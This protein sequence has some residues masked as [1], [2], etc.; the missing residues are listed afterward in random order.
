MI[1]YDFDFSGENNEILH[2]FKINNG[3]S[4]PILEKNVGY[5]IEGSFESL[6]RAQVEIDYAIAKDKQKRIKDAKYSK[7]WRDNQPEEYK[8]EHRKKALQRYYADKEYINMERNEK[9]RK[10]RRKIKEEKIKEEKIKLAKEEDQIRENEFW[11]RFSNKDIKKDFPLKKRVKRKQEDVLSILLYKIKKNINNREYNLENQ[12]I[13]EGFIELKK[14]IDKNEERMNN[15]RMEKIKE[16]TLTTMSELE[17]EFN[18][19]KKGM[20]ENP[21]L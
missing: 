4:T 15:K 21:C 10:Q 9:Q 14:R 20:E 7:K 6:E 8:E 13:L 3:K 16:E 12:R 11:S 17:K 2:V 19:E 18:T 5:D 1:E